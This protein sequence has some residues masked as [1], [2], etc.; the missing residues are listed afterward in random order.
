MSE[1]RRLPPIINLF[2]LIML[3][4]GC[5][6]QTALSVTRPAPGLRLKLNLSQAAPFRLLSPSRL[7]DVRMIRFCLIEHTRGIS[8]AGSENLAP[9]GQVFAYQVTQAL[10]LEL[11]FAN[12]RANSPGKSYSLAVAALDQNGNNITN[13]TGDNAAQQRVTISGETGNFYLSTGGGDPDFP[14]S[15]RVNPISYSLSGTASLSVALRLA[16]G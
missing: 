9:M 7:E 13:R 11:H 2:C 8:P 4:T 6:I 3:L 10:P 5:Q 12:V 1:Q 14:G 15:I 16:D